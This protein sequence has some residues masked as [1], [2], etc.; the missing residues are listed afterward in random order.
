MK[1]IDLAD[2]SM[3]ESLALSTAPAFLD[4]IERARQEVADGEVLSL[5]EM[6]RDLLP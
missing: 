3:A 1:K 6:K 5:A 4:L 2:T